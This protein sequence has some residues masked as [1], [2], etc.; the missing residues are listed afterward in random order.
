MGVRFV[1]RIRPSRSVAPPA[2]NGTM[3]VTPWSGHAA[4]LTPAQTRSANAHT[5]ATDTNQRKNFAA[6]IV[7]PAPRDLLA[8]IKLRALE[9]HW[10]GYL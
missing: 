7:T 1:A 9:S 6:D 8:R 5:V 2:G 4:E 10:S 3:M